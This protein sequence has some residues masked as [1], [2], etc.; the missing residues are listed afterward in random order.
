M[1]KK[2]YVYILSSFQN[3]VL[4]IGVTSDLIKRVW[5][6]KNKLVEGFTKKYN[7]DRLVYYEIYESAER[8]ITREKNMKEWKREWKIKRI[9]A[10]N[11]E[12][13]DLYEALCQ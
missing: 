3:K 13:N 4:Y 1:E 8:A 11:P 9:E 7:V 6:H 5:E 12:W 2:F 10:L